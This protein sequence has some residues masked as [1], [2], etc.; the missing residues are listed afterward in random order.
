MQQAAAALRRG[1]LRDAI[2]ALET[3]VKAAPGSSEAHRM[4]AI[5]T[6]LASDSRRSVEHFEAA[7]R[8]RPDDERSWIGLANTQLEAGSTADAVRTLEKA[9]AAIPLSGG[10][11]WRLA[12]LLVRLERVGDAL[13]QYAEAEGGSRVD[14]STEATESPWANDHNF[15]APAL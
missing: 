8:I 13:V 14:A 1:T 7:L 9:V 12:G 6:G 4:L 3:L 10:L 5:A 2:S 11:R 15:I